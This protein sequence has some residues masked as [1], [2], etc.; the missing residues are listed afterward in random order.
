MAERVDPTHVGGGQSRI[1]VAEHGLFIRYTTDSVG[2]TT[3]QET[4]SG[5]HRPSQLSSNIQFEHC[6]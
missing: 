5:R 1:P 4:R 3:S 2:Y 6:Q